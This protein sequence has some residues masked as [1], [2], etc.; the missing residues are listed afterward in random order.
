MALEN[1][2]KALNW[3]APRPDRNMQYC[4]TYYQGC[5]A[6]G[7]TRGFW[8]KSNALAFL[9]YCKSLGLETIFTTEEA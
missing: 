1:L 7:Y 9:K 8:L 2:W 6:N 4:V 5:M 3:Q